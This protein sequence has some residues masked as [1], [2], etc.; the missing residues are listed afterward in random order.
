MGREALR[1]FDKQRE[2]KA[3]TVELGIAVVD[4][5]R[6]M[7]CDAACAEVIDGFIDREETRGHEERAD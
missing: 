4:A 7:F 2:L 5:Q 6:A 1:T 3:F